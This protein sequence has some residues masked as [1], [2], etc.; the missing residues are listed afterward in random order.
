MAKTVLV[1]GTDLITPPALDLLLSRGFEIR[2]IPRDDLDAEELH[3]ALTGVAG[4]LIG[5]YEEASAEHIERATAL[6]VLAF[7]GTD[8]KAY[9]PGWREAIGSGVAVASCPGTNATSVAEFAVMLM[10]SMARPSLW[11]AVVESA[12]APP[13]VELRGKTLGIVGMGEIGRK[14]AK[15]AGDGLG[16]ELIY[17]SPR[18]ADADYGRHVGLDEL[19]RSAH[20]VS[21]HRPGPARGEPFA[22][23]GDE[24]ARMRHGAILID[25]AH[26]DLVD[27]SALA[28]AIEA[29][30]LRAAVEGADGRADWSPLAALGPPRFLGLPTTA[31]NTVEANGRTALCAAQAICDVLLGGESDVVSNPDFRRVRRALRQDPSGRDAP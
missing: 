30:E 20:V 15:A 5:G 24:L 28:W 11:R 22:L 29:K 6:E 26:P 18:P 4:Y 23:G 19:L 1:T 27:P 13:D 9:V 2:R 12:S 31:Y 17:S 10:L 3:A 16:M 7:T 25:T 14:V 21:L 8:Y